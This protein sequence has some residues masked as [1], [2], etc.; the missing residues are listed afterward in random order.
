MKKVDDNYSYDELEGFEP[1]DP[2]QKSIRDELI[3][4]SI[5]G[6]QMIFSLAALAALGSPEYVTV[7][8]N[9]ERKMVLF[10]KA[11]H[12]DMAALRVRARQKKN[13]VRSITESQKL[14]AELEKMTNKDLLTV[15]LLV[16]GSKAK[17]L[18][19]AVI[20][21]LRQAQVE[22]KRQVGRAG[23]RNVK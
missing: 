22:K 8:L 18:R 19:D 4:M 6:R 10:R 23:L 5:H 1:F 17:T 21:D 7:H 15:N 3:Q 2:D 12:T 20:F 11:D 13:K 16:P 14:R 9:R